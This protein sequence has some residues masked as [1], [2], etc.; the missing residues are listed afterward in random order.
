[1]KTNGKTRKRRNKRVFHRNK[2]VDAVLIVNNEKN[3]IP[4]YVG[5]NGLIEMAFAHVLGKKIF[6]WNSIPKMN[7]TDEIEAMNPIALNK[8]LDNIK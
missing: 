4:S 1:M 7:Y 8:S 6:L 3:E 5:G 2:K